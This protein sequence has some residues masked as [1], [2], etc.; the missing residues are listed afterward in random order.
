[1][2]SILHL[3]SDDSG[4]AGLKSL[5][6]LV[7]VLVGR[8]ELSLVVTA[9]ITNDDLGRILV[10]HDYRGLGQSTSESIGVVGLQRFFE[11]AS[12]QVVPD[13]KL[14]LREGSYFR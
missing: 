2:F 5:W 7:Q 1:M 9:S 10:G 3:G 6:L 12:M 8:D 4:V 11:H 13:F 14:I